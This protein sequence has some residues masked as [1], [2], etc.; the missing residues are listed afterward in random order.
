[1][2]RIRPHQSLQTAVNS[3]AQL[4]AAMTTSGILSTQEEVDQAFENRVTKTFEKLL[5]QAE[6][7]NEV[8]A[9]EE[10]KEDAKPSSRPSG[11]RS[12][13][14]KKGGSKGGSGKKTFTVEEAGNVRIGFGA[15]GPDKE[16]PDSVG[17]T[18][19]EV[20]NMSASEATDYGYEKPGK[21]WLEWAQENATSGYLRDAIETYVD[22]VKNGEAE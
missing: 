11:N 10:A 5:E 15:F 9:A 12:G 20:F 1:M 4:V 8:I 21:K 3:S 18:I 17:C 22:G 6:K 13:G 19:A 2:Y 7:D 16:D 14:A